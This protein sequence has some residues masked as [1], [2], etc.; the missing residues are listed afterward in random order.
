[1]RF[2]Y[3]VSFESD[4]K[5]VHT[6][7]GEVDRPDEETALKTAVFLAFKAKPRGSY[8]S[9]VICVERL[10]RQETDIDAIRDQ[11]DAAGHD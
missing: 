7:R 10:E 8:R 9:W 2:R 11:R 3:A 6:V 5:P 1:M 4:T